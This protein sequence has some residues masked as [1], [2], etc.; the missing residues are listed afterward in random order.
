MDYASKRSVKGNKTGNVRAHLRF[1]DEVWFRRAGIRRRGAAGHTAAIIFAG[2]LAAQWTSRRG[3][4]TPLE[5]AYRIC[6]DCKIDRPGVEALISA[7]NHAN[8][9]REQNSLNLRVAR[10]DQHRSRDADEQRHG[11]QAP[12][13]RGRD[14]G[15]RRRRELNFVKIHLDARISGSL[16]P[17]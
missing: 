2:G 12:V 11:Q 7:T 6:D 13:R 1:E 5:R 16:E 15:G 3:P 9:T 17:V 10:A 14:G 4:V 8:L